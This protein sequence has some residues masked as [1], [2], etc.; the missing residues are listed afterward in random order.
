MP[1]ASVPNTV[2]SL[3]FLAAFLAPVIAYGSYLVRVRTLRLPAWKT[4]ARNPE[5]AAAGCQTVLVAVMIGIALL[6]P[7]TAWAALGDQILS[8]AW[9]RCEA[10]LYL[11]RTCHPGRWATLY[12]RVTSLTPVQHVG[13]HWLAVMPQ[14]GEGNAVTAFGKRIMDVAGGL[15]GTAGHP[16][17]GGPARA[18]RRGGA[19][20][21]LKPEDL[22]LPSSW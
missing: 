9:R 4:S 14:L 12:E 1:P 10:A 2:R 15:V 19:D 7:T 22:L 6:G 13:D 17:G 5:K 21:R 3:P 11:T 16:G 20:R 8:L 18:G